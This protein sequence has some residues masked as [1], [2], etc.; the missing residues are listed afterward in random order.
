MSPLSHLFFFRIQ[1]VI[2]P[3]Y[4]SVFK[5]LQ[6]FNKMQSACLKSVVVTTMQLLIELNF[7]VRGT[8]FICFHKGILFRQLHS[9]EVRMIKY[10]V[11]VFHHQNIFIT[12][13]PLFFDLS[14][15]TGSGKT[16]L[17]ELAVVRHLINS[18]Y[19][20][21]RQLSSRIIYSKLF[22]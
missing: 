6:V 8:N 1:G 5:G 14:A 15:P 3:F 18:N 22:L 10:F 21:S 16:L 19:H 2:P 13:T 11:V 4:Q 20:D 12:H 17:M 9:C 7:D